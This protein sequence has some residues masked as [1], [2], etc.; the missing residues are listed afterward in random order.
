V[1]GRLLPGATAGLK[2]AFASGLSHG[3]TSLVVT[4]QADRA[5]NL[6]QRKNVLT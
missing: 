2:R 5:K 4:T 1:L 3:K 6:K